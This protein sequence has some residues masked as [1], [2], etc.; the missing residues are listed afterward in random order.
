MKIL[1]KV[2]SFL[3]IFLCV[4]IAQNSYG[5]KQ[6]K[7]DVFDIKEINRYENEDDPKNLTY[8]EFEVT[9]ISGNDICEYTIIMFIGEKVK[10]AGN[11]KPYGIYISSRTKTV[12]AGET[13]SFKA[14]FDRSTVKRSKVYAF[15]VAFSFC[16][17]EL[18]LSNLKQEKVNID[19]VT[20]IFI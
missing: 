19:L 5:G 14:S 8:F 16:K 10:E 1:K 11:I 20:P 2:F 17:T 6:Y 13:F 15:D 9:N 7:G 18:N 4:L 12:K 3:I